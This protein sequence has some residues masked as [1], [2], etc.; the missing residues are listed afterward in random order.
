MGVLEPTVTA[1][2]RRWLA[3]SAPQPLSPAFTTS[4]QATEVLE[5]A[6][7]GWLSKHDVLSIL[8]EWRTW[9]LPVSGTAPNKPGGTP[10]PRKI[11]SGHATGR[12]Q[13]S[14]HAGGT[15]FLFDRSVVRLFR[16]D[17]HA[18]RRKSDGRAVRETHEKLK[19][20]DSRCLLR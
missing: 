16:S 8:T 5:K 14:Q 13:R 19:A 9:S 12:N 15:C 18:W 2:S 6:K 10:L 1:E 4:T 17:G 11:I 7:K 20:S 3:N